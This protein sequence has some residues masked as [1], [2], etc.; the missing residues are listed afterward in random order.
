M[1]RV[2][3]AVAVLGILALPWAASTLQAA[4]NTTVDVVMSIQSLSVSAIKVFDPVAVVPAS[5]K[6]V[7]GRAVFT[8]DGNGSEDFS[9]RIASTSGSSW[10]PET[11][12][13]VVPQDAYRLRAIWAVFNATTTTAS[14]DDDDILTT[15]NQLSSATKFFSGTGTAGNVGT[16]A[17]NGGYNVPNTGGDPQRH[18]FFRFDSGASG[19]TGTATAY[20]NV[21]ATATP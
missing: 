11:G 5:A 7:K 13:G 20:V 16:A 15:S 9:I 6:V 8:N 18:L 2:I 21:T 17:V 14:F 12:T 3:A 1:K 10:T 4:D 19:T